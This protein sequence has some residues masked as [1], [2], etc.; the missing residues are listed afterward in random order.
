MLHLIIVI[1]ENM[2]WV[3]WEEWVSKVEEDLLV[4]FYFLYYLKY[5]F[6]GTYFIFT[7]LQDAKDVPPDALPNPIENVNWVEILVII[8]HTLLIG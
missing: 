5:D 6:P 1:E 2:E 4:I 7:K 8:D 3:L